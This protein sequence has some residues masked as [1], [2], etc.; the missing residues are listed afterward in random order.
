[1]L[2]VNL[3]TR[4]LLIILFLCVTL[5]VF[6]FIRQLKIII[7]GYAK[8]NVSWTMEYSSKFYYFFALNAIRLMWKQLFNQRHYEN[9]CS[10]VR[11]GFPVI[12]VEFRFRV[13]YLLSVIWTCVSIVRSSD[14]QTILDI[15]GDAVSD[16]KKKK[17]RKIS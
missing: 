7:F 3:S 5:W 16:I 11:K 8:D 10:V 4:F 14:M 17:T 13:T 12:S 6:A 1:M 15:Y 2:I 9:F